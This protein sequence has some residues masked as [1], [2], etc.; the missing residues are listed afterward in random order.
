MARP[1]A[2]ATLAELEAGSAR[3]VTGEPPLLLRRESF[4]VGDVR[5]ILRES[6]IRRESEESRI[7]RESEESAA[8]GVDIANRRIGGTTSATR[9]EFRGWAG[10]ACA[11]HCI[12]HARVLAHQ[13]QR[14]LLMSEGMKLPRR[15]TDAAP[16]IR[17][18]SAECQAGPHQ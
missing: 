18:R 17:D 2:R 5:G 4:H 16:R 1:E 15:E 10:I 13:G 12:G 9:D 7:R 3:G 14:R 6:R 8:W 11:R